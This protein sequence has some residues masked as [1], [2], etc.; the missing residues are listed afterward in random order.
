M[1]NRRSIIITLLFAS[2]SILFSTGCISNF[3]TA[4]PTPRAHAVLD[5]GL[6]NNYSYQ[7]PVTSSQSSPSYNATGNISG[8]VII[9]DPG[10]GGKDPGASGH[11]VREKDINLEIAKKLAIILQNAGGRAVMTRTTDVFITLDNRAA[12][13]E[14]YNAD[15]LVSIH[16]DSI[17]KSHISGAT[18]LTGARASSS[19]KKAAWMIE[20]ALEN[21]G[22]SCRA[23][24]SQ[25]L[26]VCDGHSKPAV[27]V[28]TGF[29][30]NRQEARNLDT[31]WYQNKVANAIASGV[32]RYL[33]SN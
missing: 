13:A 1:N 16:A 30:T 17:G 9:V 23:H 8:K 15:M 10:H 29:L 14:R 4:L 7:K 6:T 21:A 5:S 11:G 3:D 27:L 31:D 24:R 12:A 2:L 20:A 32:I 18:V 26:R 25:Q 19:S 28:E 22:I 33:N